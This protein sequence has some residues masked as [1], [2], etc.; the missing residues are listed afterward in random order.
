MSAPNFF[1]RLLATGSMDANVSEFDLEIEAGHAESHYWKDLWRYRELFYF[2][3]WRDILVRY[4][5][6]LIR[7][8]W[9]FIRPFLAMVVFTV[10]LGKLVKLPS[11][12]GPYPILVFCR[13]DLKGRKLLQ[14]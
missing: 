13:R 5:Q 6:T 4:K 10:L 7:V 3:A 9:S 14:L 11:G 8:G 2:L 1:G 12:G